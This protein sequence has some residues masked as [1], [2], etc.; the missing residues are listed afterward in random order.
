MNI[1]LF[2]PPGVG[3]STL[4]G[5]LKT[6]GQSAIDLEDLYP[7]RLRFQIPNVVKDTFIGGADLNPR[8]KYRGCL[9]VLLSADQGIYEQRR[10]R[11]D[12]Q[13]PEKAS[14]SK[15]L[16]ADWTKDPSIYDL[17]LDTN[18]NGMCRDEKMERLLTEL[19]EL[20]NGK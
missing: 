6:R 1:I 5:Y 2:G 15:H 13:H 16:M 4:I 19:L 9:K 18:P 8:R 17:I 3:K 14:Q 7:S 20:R 12:Q 11:R 10:A